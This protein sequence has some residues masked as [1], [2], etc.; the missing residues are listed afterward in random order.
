MP[1][2]KKKKIDKSCDSCIKDNICYI[3]VRVV[4]LEYNQL[5]KKA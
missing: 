4:I 1:K 5:H 3:T 2:K